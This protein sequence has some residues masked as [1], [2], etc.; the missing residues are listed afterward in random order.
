MT[1]RKKPLQATSPEISCCAKQMSP[2]SCSFSLSDSFSWLSYISCCQSGGQHDESPLR[3][4]A[5]RINRGKLGTSVD[6]QNGRMGGN[7]TDRFE[8]LASASAVHSCRRQ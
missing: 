2:I 1:A 4:N 6:D 5:H 7:C 8:F 3:R